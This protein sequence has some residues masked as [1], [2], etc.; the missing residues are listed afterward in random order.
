MRFGTL[1]CKEIATSLGVAATKA[2]QAAEPALLKVAVLLEDHNLKTQETLCEAR[3]HVRAMRQHQ[4]EV[5]ARELME[6]AGA[7]PPMTTKR[8][9]DE[10]MNCS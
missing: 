1:T 7:A 5:K 2:T 9:N 10:E 3:R 6:R 4:A 8:R